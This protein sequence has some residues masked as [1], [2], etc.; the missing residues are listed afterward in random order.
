MMIKKSENIDRLL[1][2]KRVADRMGVESQH[3]T[4]LQRYINERK[5][6]SGVEI[7][8]SF[9]G[10][11]EYI[12]SHCPE[13]KYLIG[14][15]PYQYKIDFSGVRCQVDADDMYL[16]AKE[17]QKKDSR[18]LLVRESSGCFFRANG[19]QFN[20]VFIDGDH[21]YEQ[22]I[23]DIRNA[24]KIISPGGLLCGHDYK[25]MPGVTLA[26]DEFAKEIGKPLIEEIGTVWMFEY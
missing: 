9:G 25:N 18:F 10:H 22:V 19:F 23:E 15:D 8:V 7:G 6:L 14:V 1:D 12:L 20:F 21:D 13:L 16:I 3:Y 5:Y 26:V 2:V 11:C 17:L 24:A 4:V